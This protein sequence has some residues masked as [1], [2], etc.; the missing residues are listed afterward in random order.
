MADSALESF[1]S[2]DLIAVKINNDIAGLDS[3][4]FS[5]RS[6]YDIADNH[7]GRNIIKLYIAGINGTDE[8]NSLSLPLKDIIKKAQHATIYLDGQDQP[9]DIQNVKPSELPTVI[10]CQPRGGFVIIIS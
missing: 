10:T 9:W 6:C 8:T 4:L 5:R 7:T 3:S 2:A 1:H